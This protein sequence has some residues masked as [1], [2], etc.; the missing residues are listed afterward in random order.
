MSGNN[1]NIILRHPFGQKTF[2]FFSLLLYSRVYVRR[3]FLMNA[4]ACCSK[5]VPYLL[6][7][8]TP[9][10]AGIGREEEEYVD[11]P[12]QRDFLGL[13]VIWE[14][15]IKGALRTNYRICSESRA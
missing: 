6:F 8:V 4:Q 11:L 1:V 5:A 13:P 9:I 14:S 3:G 15:S 10:H 7:A 2:Y 12:I